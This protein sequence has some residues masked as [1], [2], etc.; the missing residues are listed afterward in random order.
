MP[1]CEQKET[2]VYYA[3]KTVKKKSLK[4]L[5]AIED[6]KRVR[7]KVYRSVCTQKQMDSFL[8]PRAFTNDESRFFASSGA[9]KCI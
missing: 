3:V 4:N 1:R 2:G 7:R 9:H 5:D 6:T 8:E